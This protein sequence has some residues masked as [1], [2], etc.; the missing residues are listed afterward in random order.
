MS[1]REVQRTKGVLPGELVETGKGLSSRENI[2]DLYL[3]PDHDRLIRRGGSGPY[4][5]FLVGRP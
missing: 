5:K 1:S 3:L 4:R 2:K